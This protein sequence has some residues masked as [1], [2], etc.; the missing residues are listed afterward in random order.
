[1]VDSA[2]VQCKGQSN[3]TIT[4]DPTVKVWQAPCDKNQKNELKLEFICGKEYIFDKF[5]IN[6][7]FQKLEQ[8]SFW[9]NGLVW[10]SSNFMS[11]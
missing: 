2:R 10:V 6:I 4:V 5:I 8:N 3:C 9:F 7:S 11:C 1:M